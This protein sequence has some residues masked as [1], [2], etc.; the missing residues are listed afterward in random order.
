MLKFNINVILT[1]TLFNIIL[2]QQD[3]VENSK[4]ISRDKEKFYTCVHHSIT[5]DNKKIAMNNIVV[6]ISILT[7]TFFKVI[8]HILG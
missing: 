4:A 8:F 6:V 2:S 1:F 5:Y 7:C 3:E